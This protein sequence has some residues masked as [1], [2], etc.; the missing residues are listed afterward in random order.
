MR[1]T[2]HLAKAA[3]FLTVALLH[4]FI[5]V[6]AP[7]LASKILAVVVALLCIVVGVRN[8]WLHYHEN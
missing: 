3:L 5:I 7:W 6:I 8:I 1:E 2:L 4:I